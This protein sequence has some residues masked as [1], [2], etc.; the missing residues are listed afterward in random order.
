[1]ADYYNLVCFQVPMDPEPAAYAIRLNDLSN[2]G[3]VED[4]EIIEDVKDIWDG[5]FCFFE[6]SEDEQL[7]TITAEESANIESLAMLLQIVQRKYD[8]NEPIAFEYASTSSRPILNA[9][10][11]GLVVVTKNQINLHDT[12]SWC[13]GLLTHEYETMAQNEGAKLTG[14][15]IRHAWRMLSEVPVTDDG[16]TMMSFR[17]F[18]AHTHRETIWHWFEK[19][20]PSFSV[21]EAMGVS[22]PRP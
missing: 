17:H 19:Q 16:H 11:G 20:D 10:G 2:Q 5:T 18:P 9:C 22:N 3:S 8:L 7:L 4:G 14:A 12:R 6:Y 1:M 15:E 21:A 13:H